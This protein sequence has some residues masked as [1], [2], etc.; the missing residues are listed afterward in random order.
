MTAVIKL[1]YYLTAL[2]LLI[3][4][5]FGWDT[6]GVVDSFSLTMSAIITVP[7]NL[8]LIV[9]ALT[10]RVSDKNK[11]WG[12]KVFLAVATTLGVIN[13]ILPAVLLGQA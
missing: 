11:T 1:G 12:R 5:F 7:I 6:I 2:L 10:L 9:L 3:S 8:L 4:V 13:L